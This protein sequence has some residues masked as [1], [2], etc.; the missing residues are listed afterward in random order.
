MIFERLVCQP[1][2]ETNIFSYFKCEIKHVSRR[3][4]RIHLE[5]NLTRPL[6]G[7]HVHSVAYY[8]YNTYQR[9]AINLWED[10]CG[11]LNGT[12]RSYFMDFT[13][14]KV[15]NYSNFN[16]PCPYEGNMFLKVKNI[17][18]DNFPFEHL[19]PSGRYRLDVNLTE[20]NKEKVIVMLQLFASVSDHR[21][22]QY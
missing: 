7:V 9:W 12:K 17:S 11:W 14:K 1:N 20:E 19:V 5:L 13:V 16:H 2:P 8:K 21:I 10:V 4:L 6:R 18:E 15:L 3:H 22:E